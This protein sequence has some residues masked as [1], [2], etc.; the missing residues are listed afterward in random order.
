MEFP[1]EI[2]CIVYEKMLETQCLGVVYMPYDTELVPVDEVGPS[3][4]PMTIPRWLEVS[5]LDIVHESTPRTTFVNL[6]C[7]IYM[8]PLPI[9]FGICRESRQH[10]MHQILRDLEQ[11]RG[12][13]RENT[14]IFSHDH[15]VYYATQHVEGHDWW[16]SPRIGWQTALMIRLLGL[17]NRVGLV[18]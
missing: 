3:T 5:S 8:A 7:S 1:Y 2:R 4:L 12:C 14:V 10:I 18:S 6:Q 11:A 13:R 17:L 15:M 16:P 9:I